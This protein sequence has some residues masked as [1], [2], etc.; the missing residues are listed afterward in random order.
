MKYKINDR[1][2][3]FITLLEDKENASTFNHFKNKEYK[4]I[5][6]AMHTETEE[7]LVIYQAEYGDH[8]TYARPATMFF[9][10][11]DKTKYPEATQKY[12][13]DLKK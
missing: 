13:F 1:E 5:T 9:S 4:I 10:E 2:L 11:V 8:L 3:E 6:I 7:D 12:R